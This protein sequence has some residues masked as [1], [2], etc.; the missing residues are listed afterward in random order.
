[1]QPNNIP[2]EA[3]AETRSR[4]RVCGCVVCGECWGS[5]RVR[6]EGNYC[7]DL[8]ACHDCDGCGIS[9]ECADC[10]LQREMDFDNGGAANA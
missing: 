5:G 2:S 1:M 7:D 4:F 10:E 6:V 8:E 3:L 9:E